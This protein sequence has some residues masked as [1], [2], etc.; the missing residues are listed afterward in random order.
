M[1]TTSYPLITPNLNASQDLNQTSPVLSWSFFDAIA[2]PVILLIVLGNLIVLLVVIVYRKELLTTSYNCFVLSLSISDFVIG[3]SLSI[4]SLSDV[5]PVLK[6]NYYLCVLQVIA[7]NTMMDM[8]TLIQILVINIDVL[9]AIVFPLKHKIYFTAGRAKWMITGVWAVAIIIT[10]LHACF[11]HGPEYL[12]EC[13]FKSLLKEN[14]DAFNILTS[15]IF[16]TIYFAQVTIFCLNV[17]KLKKVAYKKNLYGKFV[18]AF[19]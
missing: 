1:D 7:L 13:S 3:L 15:V 4:P 12:E 2:I 8:A 16:C 19:C 10:A 5:F 11:L 17:N 14:D 18:N 6:S 9:V